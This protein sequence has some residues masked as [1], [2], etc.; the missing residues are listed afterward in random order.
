MVIA[1]FDNDV[2]SWEWSGRVS[3]RHVKRGIQAGRELMIYGV[4]T[5]P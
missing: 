2:P 4:T 1:N 5:S 3:V